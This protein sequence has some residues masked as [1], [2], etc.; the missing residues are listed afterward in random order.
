MKYLGAI[1]DDLDLVT[2]EYVDDAL[3][4]IN[5]SRVETTSAETTIAAGG[6]AWISVPYPSKTPLAIVGYYVQGTNNTK[7]IIYAQ[8]FATNNAFAACSNTATSQAKIKVTYY[9]LV[10]G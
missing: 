5:Y 4:S 10:I 7:T 1:T 8:Q 2:K 3:K 6:T 9:W